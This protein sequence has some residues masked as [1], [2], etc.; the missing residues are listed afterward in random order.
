MPREKP[1]TTVHIKIENR[2]G[3]F[4]VSSDDVQGFWLW[5]RDPAQVFESII[6]TLEQLYKYN[7]GLT[8]KVK[9]AQ[10]TSRQERWFGG[11]G[12]SCRRFQ[13]W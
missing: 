3:I 7:E 12:R 1:M 10:P 9:E 2:E 11:G 13:C 8:V 6:P 4:Y 5:G